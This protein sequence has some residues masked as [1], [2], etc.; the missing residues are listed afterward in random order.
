MENG[1]GQLYKAVSVKNLDKSC[2]TVL[3]GIGVFFIV[4][5]LLQIVRGVPFSENF[6]L[7][8]L[9]SLCLYACTF[10]QNCW[11]D[12][13]GIH[14]ERKT[15]LCRSEEFLPWEDIFDITFVVKKSVGDYAPAYFS[16]LEKTGWK[17]IFKK[18]EI[19]QIKELAEL[20]LAD[21]ENIYIS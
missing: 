11:L 17:L 7:L 8:L 3:M 9:G 21:P 1:E 13:K 18:N 15:A 6:Y 10:R 4:D 2:L 19:P 5:I 14:R 16:N 12:E 20:K